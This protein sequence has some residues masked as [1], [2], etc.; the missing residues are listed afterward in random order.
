M[1]AE[2]NHRVCG[3]DG[4]LQLLWRRRC[5]NTLPAFDDIVVI[6]AATVFVA[7]IADVGVVDV[8]AAPDICGHSFRVTQCPARVV[9]FVPPETGWLF[10]SRVLMCERTGM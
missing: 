6:V 3:V 4:L 8:S 7:A 10:F 5:A 9:G 2:N 1:L